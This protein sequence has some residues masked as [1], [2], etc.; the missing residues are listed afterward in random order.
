MV[1]FIICMSVLVA[2]IALW[3]WASHARK[4]ARRRSLMEKYGDAEIVNRIM[5]RMFWEGQSYEQL[6]DSLGAP[7]DVDEK[8]MK[9]KVRHVCKYGRTGVNRFRLRIT[10]ENG[11]VVGWEQK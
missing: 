11:V 10:L 4:A 3:I 5:N 7:A 6:Q 8:V 1:G 9:S 2:V